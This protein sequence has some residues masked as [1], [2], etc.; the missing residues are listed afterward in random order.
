MTRGGG[1][2]PG[3]GRAAGGRAGN[4]YTRP[5]PAPALVGLASPDMVPALLERVCQP[6]P[7]TGKARPLL[8]GPGSVSAV[9]EGLEAA[10][11]ELRRQ[12]AGRLLDDGDDIVRMVAVK[13]AQ[14]DRRQVARLA[15]RADPFTLAGLALNDG[16]P[17][18]LLGRL[19]G[20]PDRRVQLAVAD[21]PRTPLG[22][23]LG[24]LRSQFPEVAR[25]AADHRNMPAATR[26][27]YQLASGS[28]P[29]SSEPYAPASRV[30]R[31]YLQDP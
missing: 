18:R 3:C 15:R 13:C 24:L 12:L 26:A 10:G 14:L 20:H 23:L 17:E 30:L 22:P 8:S 2:V 6:S 4:Q 1:P 9:L 31:R 21:N 19:A 7:G 11:P 16:C 29:S 27:M 25:R 5:R 28:S